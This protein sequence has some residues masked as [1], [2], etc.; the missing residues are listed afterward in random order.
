MEDRGGGHAAL[1]MV[2]A[3]GVEPISGMRSIT[4]ST[5]LGDD[6]QPRTNLR[7]ASECGDGSGRD[8]DDRRETE[9][10]NVGTTRLLVGCRLLDARFT[11]ERHRS[12]CACTLT[13]SS[14]PVRPRLE[15]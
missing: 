5:C 1:E 7:G 3:M 8:G 14:K 4:G 13:I 10:Q 2:E 11:T 9:R 12:A 6:H 15:M